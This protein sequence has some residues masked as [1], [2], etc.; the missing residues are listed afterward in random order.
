MV[1]IS[2]GESPEPRAWHSLELWDDVLLVYGGRG[3]VWDG[4]SLQE[5]PGVSS[6]AC[7]DVGD[8]GTHLLGDLW[9]MDLADALGDW[10]EGEDGSVH[11]QQVRIDR[12]SSARGPRTA[13]DWLRV[14]TFLAIVARRA[15]SLMLSVRS[16]PRDPGARRGG[17]DL[18]K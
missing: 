14:S 5:Q 17:L 9:K 4:I 10:N 16:N 8:L 13:N 6:A 3:G 11:F 2:S 12:S 7:G 15:V 18:T 1:P